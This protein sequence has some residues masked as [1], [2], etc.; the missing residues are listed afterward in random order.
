MTE[1]NQLN[2]ELSGFDH[3]QVTIEEEDWLKIYDRQNEHA[4]L[5]CDTTATVR[6]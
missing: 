1:E 6:Q 4:W 5:M 3:S 2:L